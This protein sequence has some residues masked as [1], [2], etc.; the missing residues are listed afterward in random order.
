MGESHE[1]SL[2]EKLGFR[3]GDSI[4]IETTPGWYTKFADDAQLVLEPGLPAT[5]A[6][7][8]CRNKTE[9]TDFLHES[10]LPQIEQSLW[11]SWLKRS[12]KQRTDLT[13]NDIRAA[14]LPFGWVDTKIVS[15]DPDWSGLKFV[16]RKRV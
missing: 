16:R 3:P 11:V 1:K 5:H 6:H 13:D 12:A 10:D 4:F 7:I 2:A 8:F 9:L 14:I 15:V